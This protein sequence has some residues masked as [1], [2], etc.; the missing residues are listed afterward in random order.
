MDDDGPA[1]IRA[2]FRFPRCRLAVIL[3][4]VAAI[5][6]AFASGYDA[7]SRRHEDRVFEEGRRQMLET[8]VNCIRLGII[9]VNEGRLRELAEG[10]GTNA[11]TGA[12]SAGG[13]QGEP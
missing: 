4:A 13:R 12:G 11:E 9:E 1:T 7:S 6:V 2:S 10:A 3:I 8:L 5:A